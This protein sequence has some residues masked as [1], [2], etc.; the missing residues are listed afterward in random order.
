[1]LPASII[2]VSRR[3]IYELESAAISK[4][5]GLASF[6]D[7][8]PRPAFASFLR[9][10]FLNVTRRLGFCPTCQGAIWSDLSSG[11][12]L[13]D[14]LLLSVGLGLIFYCGRLLIKRSRSFKFSADEQTT[15]QT[16]SDR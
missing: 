6:E 15:G 3:E 4:V 2:F 8:R 5:L 12:S 9:C 10:V 16:C 13:V 14:F 11:L 7:A 1:M